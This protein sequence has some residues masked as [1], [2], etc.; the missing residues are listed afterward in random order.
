M[1]MV[2]KT[3]VGLTAAL[4]CVTGPA[5]ASTDSEVENELA[6]MRELVEGL[7][8]QVEAQE[9][10]IHHQGEM[11]EDAQRV[12][13][14]VQSDVEDGTLS[15]LSDFWGAVDVNMS[16]AG[17]YAWNFANP[18][19]ATGAGGFGPARISGTPGI[20]ANNG[21]VAILPFHPD[22]NSF[23][24]DQVWFDIGKAP[25]EESRA[26]F[27]F[28]LLYGTT[29]TFLGQGSSAGAR[30]RGDS[31]SDYYV[32]QAYVSYLAPLGEGVEVKFGKFGTLI[33][34][35]VADTTANNHITLANLYQ[36]FQP[37][38]HLGV[39][40]ST[41][42]GPVSITGAVVNEGTLAVSSPDV[43]KEKGYLGQIAFAASDELS[44]AVTILYTRDG[45]GLAG[46]AGLAPNVP[47]LGQ[48]DRANGTLD[49]LL[50]YDSDAF[51][52]YVNS[53]LFWIEGS[54][55]A[56]W[57]IAV[58]GKVPITDAFSAAARLEYAR[59]WDNV[60]GFGPAIPGIGGAPV[61]AP[62]RNSHIYSAVGTLAYEVAENLTVR[63]EVRWD[64]VKEDT[65]FPGVLEV[66]A[67][68]SNT[69]GGRED[70][71][72]GLAQVIYAF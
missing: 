6:E 46:N 34:A 12:V 2:G 15:S 58:S 36:L 27:H 49:F 53:D 21:R 67:F 3:L 7:K 66:D 28:T 30:A 71:I 64:R 29:A 70:Q 57:G 4:V 68:F 55:L 8:Q 72:V 10:Q 19:L 9:E 56:G 22:H 61:F 26:G 60:L 5:F 59:D 23:Q 33:G 25:T 41:S 51:S 17:S 65:S 39:M 50:T 37:I 42:F 11:L 44:T 32:H 45:P 1:T 43:N 52:A 47:G 48:N 14:D 24:I 40:A 18:D 13:R 38:D 31:T 54:G 20:G 63:G 69:A 62:G 16:V 35:E